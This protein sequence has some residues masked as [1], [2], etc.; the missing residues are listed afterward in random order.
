[1]GTKPRIYVAISTFYP[2]V[3]GAETQTLAQC[4]R[5]IE[6]GYPTRVVT[7]HHKHI[8]TPYARV[9]DVPIQRVAG[10]LLGKR[11]KL[12]RILQR[13][14]YFLAMLVMAFTVWRERHNFDILQVCQFSLLV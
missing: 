10:K 4:Q 5:L 13:A 3:G 7:F 11:E 12:P 9:K 2:L 1:M 14:L 6:T 8:W